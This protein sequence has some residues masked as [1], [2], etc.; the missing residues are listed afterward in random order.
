MLESSADGGHLVK[1][2][3]ASRAGV[4]DSRHL[5]SESS[6]AP[7]G[8]VSGRARPSRSRSTCRGRLAG[9]VRIARR[10]RRK[11]RRHGLAGTGLPGC[12]S[13]TGRRGRPRRWRSGQVSLSSGGDPHG[14]PRHHEQEDPP[15]SL[16]HFA[17][18]PFFA[19]GHCPA[20]TASDRASFQGGRIFRMSEQLPCR[21]PPRG[22][23]AP[24]HA[25]DPVRGRQP[26]T[27]SRRACFAA[28]SSS[29]DRCSR[30]TRP[31]VS[32]TK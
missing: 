26:V 13:R 5:C 1:S 17:R 21:L 25:R 14:R 10:S 20:P 9:R 23:V 3:S 32:S 29:T 8:A 2:L 31:W 19:C 24:G 7:S 4:V 30:L 27:F 18:L 6:R 15:R 28:T 11:I 16:Q 22:R 12:G